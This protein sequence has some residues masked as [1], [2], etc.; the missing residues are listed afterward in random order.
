VA[1]NLNDAVIT[2]D[3]KFRIQSWNRAAE[4]IYGWC[5]EAVIGKLVEDILHTDYGT[6]V[7]RTAL[8]Q[9][10]LAQGWWQG[11]VI[12]HRQDHTLINMLS[13][14][15]FLRDEQGAPMGVLLINRDITERK[16][17]EAALRE[18]RDLLQL[19]IDKIPGV[20]I[21]HD[22]E[23][24]FQLVN[25]YFAE[26]F[27]CTPADVV[28]KTHLEFMEPSAGL[29]VIEQRNERA[30]AT[31]QP[32]FIPEEK[33]FDYI[34][35]THCIPLQN[36][37]GEYDRLLVVAMDVPE[38]Y[39]AEEAIRRSEE[40]FRQIVTTMQGGLV[41]YDIAERITYAN[42]RFCELSGYALPELIGATS[43]SLV[44]PEYAP[45][46][47]AQLAHRR[48]GES[49]TYEIV[50]KRKDGQRVHWL[51]SGSPWYDDQHT[52]MGSA[53]V[54]IDITAQ[55]QAESVLQNALQKERELSALKS[56]FVSTASHELRTPLAS[57]LAYTETLRAYRHKLSDEQI[58]QR[59]DGIHERIGVL[60]AII[61]DV[62]Q[63]ER[64]QTGGVEI[65][66]I[67]VDLDGLCRMVIDEFQTQPD[68][69]H[70]LHYHC[71]VAP[72]L[73]ALD[74]NLM[75]QILANLVGNA[76]KYSAPATTV[77]VAL[78]YTDAQLSLSVQDEGMGIPPDDL[79][80]LF[81]PFQRASNVGAIGGTGLGLVIAKEAV[82]LHGGAIT[83]TS[84]LGVGTTF[85]V[86]IP[87]LPVA[88]IAND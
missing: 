51:V 23:H 60:R 42:E 12:Q 57:I 4:Q 29:D 66:R 30:W 46:I 58:R 13:S 40:R 59:L 22:R 70:H 71:A 19:V 14:A 75:R 74:K 2:L 15:T 83:V 88:S 64:L 6:G 67:P 47:D 55:K 9:L 77:R 11:E 25:Q 72:P 5:A 38:R 35:Q 36:A 85:T 26:R 49:T 81:Q 62:L 39:Q 17:A 44:D 27:N 10:F 79:A 53:A 20:I 82:E 21:V 84:Q 50:A 56:R 73:F 18:Q 32:L 87:T 52:M 43:Y 28:G 1:D 69:H 45:L 24:R 37:S 8:W 80:H 16:H 34:Y 7:E 78:T 31:L 48:Q 76:L 68:F 3:L 65:Q 33:V 61:D 41:I 54:V 63:L 86:T